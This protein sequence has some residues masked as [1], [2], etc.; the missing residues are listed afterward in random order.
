[1]HYLVEGTPVRVADQRQLPVG[2]VAERDHVR[3]EP[4]GRQPQYLARQ[5]LIGDTRVAAADLQAC[6]GEHH[7]HHGLPEIEVQPAGR[8]LVGY[9]G[10][11]ADR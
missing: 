1:V 4:V 9:G 8:A 6:R 11:H 7:A 2:R 3:A 5:A 10:Y